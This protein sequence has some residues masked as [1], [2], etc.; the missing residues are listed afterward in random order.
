MDNDNNKK[1]EEVGALWIQ[2]NKAGLEYFSGYIL[3]GDGERLKVVAFKNS[4]KKPGEKSPDF[5]MY[6]SKDLP[7]PEGESVAPAKKAP[8]PA[9][10]IEEESLSDEEI[11]F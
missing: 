5:R 7:K 10:V 11:P 9:P 1:K 4:Y 8:K 3:T 6:E 2:K